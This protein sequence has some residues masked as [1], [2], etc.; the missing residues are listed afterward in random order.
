MKLNTRTS[1][2]LG[3]ILTFWKW[4]R[5]YL[6][7]IYAEIIAILSRDL[8]IFDIAILPDSWRYIMI[9][10]RA[11]GA[12]MKPTP[13]YDWVLDSLPD[14]MNRKSWC[15]K[16]TELSL[17]WVSSMHK[18]SMLWLCMATMS[19]INFESVSPSTFHVAIMNSSWL[20]CND[21]PLIISIL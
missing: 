12:I 9:L 16:R 18:I 6:R 4:M 19:S 20:H 1:L 3:K 7:W 15:R 5:R 10:L 2:M 8:R 13:S 14:V 21:P 11:F 17:L